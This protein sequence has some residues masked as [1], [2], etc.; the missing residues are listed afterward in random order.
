MSQAQYLLLLHVFSPLGIQSFLNKTN[1]KIQVNTGK[2]SA[3]D[4]HHQCQLET[5]PY[6][7]KFNSSFIM[8]LK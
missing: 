7:L 3:P 4:L 2:V 1:V 5:I 8:L 6:I